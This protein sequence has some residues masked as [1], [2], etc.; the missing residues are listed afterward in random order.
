MLKPVSRRSFLAAAGVTGAGL[1]LGP[2]VLSQAGAAQ[3]KQKPAAGPGGL[4]YSLVNKTNGKFTDEQCF[5]SLNG[6]GEWHSFAKEPT[7]PCAGGGR[8]YVCRRQA[9]QKHGRTSNRIGISSST[10]PGGRTWHG[11]TTQVD[12]FCIPLTIEMGDKKLGIMESRSK[13]FAASATR[14][15]RSSKPA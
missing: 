4:V 3:R 9:P 7:A 5:W 15:P 8:I 11:N 6:G 14:P 2:S 10:M 12:A 13:L 1:I